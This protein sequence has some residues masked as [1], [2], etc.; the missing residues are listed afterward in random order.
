MY[1]NAWLRMGQSGPVRNAI[2][3]HA[4]LPLA[5]PAGWDDALL[6]GLP[7][8]WRLRL[9]SRDPVA[10]CTSLAGLALT[11]CAAARLRGEAPTLHSLERGGDDG[12][13]R[14]TAGPYFSVSHAATR[15]ASVVTDRCEV[16]F[17]L[18]PVAESSRLAQLRRWTA[19]EAVLKAAGL[20]LRAT[21]EVELTDDCGEATLRAQRYVIR[22]VHLA[23]GFVAHLAAAE[24]LEPLVVELA[25][26]D[27]ELSAVVE[28]SLRLAT[29]R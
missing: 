10:R 21:R 16:G 27:G 22:R 7:Y 15:V 18:E 1:A 5:A 23:P 9:E 12:K 17:D 14:L 8:A 25:P 20:G 28:R 24:C 19:T 26:D 3:L 2:L 11:L 29:Q 4:T 13:P 6:Q